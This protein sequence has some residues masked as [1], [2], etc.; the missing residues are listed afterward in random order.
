MA[1]HPVLRESFVRSG[2]PPFE[3]GRLKCPEC[4]RQLY[5]M[6]YLTSQRWQFAPVT[7]VD[8]L[9]RAGRRML[10][11]RLRRWGGITLAVLLGAVVARAFLIL[12]L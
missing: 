8:R 2:P 10:L 11:L 5:L 4:G 7:D 3:W 6:R 12:L 1:L 9:R